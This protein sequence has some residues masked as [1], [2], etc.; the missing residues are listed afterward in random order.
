MHFWEAAEK[1]GS[2]GEDAFWK[3]RGFLFLHSALCFLGSAKNE[4]D[5]A[6]VYRCQPPGDTLQRLR[7]NTT[8]QSDAMVIS[9][10]GIPIFSNGVVVTETAA[11]DAHT[12]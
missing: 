6:G 3:S 2:R 5:K 9:L 12:K 10:P 11:H 4:D 1:A 7:D 8:G